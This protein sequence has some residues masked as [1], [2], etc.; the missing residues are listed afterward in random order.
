[1]VT[2][3]PQP[4]FIGSSPSE[5]V[6]QA[7]D[8]GQKYA[9]MYQQGLQ[10]TAKNFLTGKQIEVERQKVEMQAKYNDEM[11]A[12]RM[13]AEDQAR[14][15][16]IEKEFLGG[17]E[18][19]DPSEHY[20]YLLENKPLAMKYFGGLANGDKD[21]TKQFYESAMK[22]A[23]DIASA[24][25]LVRAGGMSF[26]AAPAVPGAA[27]QPQQQVAAPA[28][29]PPVPPGAP[30]PARPQMQ[31]NANPIGSPTAL[32]GGAITPPA[33]SAIAPTATVG[34]MS[35]AASQ[36]TRG[37]ITESLNISTTTPRTAL[38]SAVLEKFERQALTGDVSP[39]EQTAVRSALAPTL[40][41]LENSSIV[42]DLEKSGITLQAIQT[43][44]DELNRAMAADPQFRDWMQSSSSLD[45][46]TAKSFLAYA[47][48]D[49]SFAMA[50]KRLELVQEGLDVKEGQ[51]TLNA[52]KIEESLRLG[53]KRAQTQGKNAETAAYYAANQAMTAY[54]QH[55]TSEVQSYVAANKGDAKA[56][57][58][59]NIDRYMD[60]L[61]SDVNKNSGIAQE[62]GW[63]AWLVGRATGQPVN[64][65]QAQLEGKNGF[66]FWG[67]ES[68]VDYTKPGVSGVIT[69]SPAGSAQP[70]PSPQPAKPN[71]PK[72]PTPQQAQSSDQDLL[73]AAR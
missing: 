6:M 43:K 3:I 61:F 62:A 4:Q 12:Q 29:T 73:N 37:S 58:Q 65:V 13:S 47:K 33:P 22:T 72:T 17:M 1:M 42:Q 59:E 31:Q 15:L 21:L 56:L 68:A 18:K 9:A 57:K 46:A 30:M 64:I 2:R 67:G 38:A 44:A 48:Q 5:V 19:V 39:K 66:L 7:A 32:P 41:V 23:V 14:Q 45:P 20:N 24:P 54:S 71:A 60:S 52:A 49:D 16:S 26:G 36:S 10:D 63:T 35:Q 34:A 50:S 51:L 27:T 53:W 40:K 25:S 55:W 70:N 8:L 69:P 11:T 28:P